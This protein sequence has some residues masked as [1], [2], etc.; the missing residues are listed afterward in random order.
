M[1]I[2]AFRRGFFFKRAG[3]PGEDVQRQEY[4]RQNSESANT[5]H[6]WLP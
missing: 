2:P 5:S 3:T 6:T 4:S 1:K